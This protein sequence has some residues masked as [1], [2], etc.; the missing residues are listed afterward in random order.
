MSFLKARIEI[1]PA[2]VGTGVKISLMKTKKSAARLS[3]ILTP[4]T[5]RNFDWANG[6]KLE[7]LIGDGEHH[8]LL[9]LRKNNSVGQ[10]VVEQ[11]KT[12]KGEWFSIK[13]G[14]Q[15]AFVDRSEPARWCQWE[16]IEDGYVEI[17]LPTWA[18]ETGPKKRASAP[19]TPSAPAVARKVASVTG[20]LMGDPEPGR[21]EA[22][23]KLA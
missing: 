19:A 5:A 22:L 2:S 3:L 11:R 10:A 8:G 13:L 9:R 18:D 7:V 23:A 15:D 21:R 20:Q 6:D 16:K 1:K 12:A 4:V 17:V 14:H